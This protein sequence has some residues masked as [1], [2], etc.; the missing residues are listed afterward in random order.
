MCL[1]L[2]SYLSEYEFLI[3]DLLLIFPLAILIARTGAYKQLTP[4]QPTG[5][6]ISVPII[7]SVLLQS[8]IQFLAQV[9]FIEIYKIR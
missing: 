9:R 8:L 5:A 4:H 2:G 6:L 7:S 3:V 1:T